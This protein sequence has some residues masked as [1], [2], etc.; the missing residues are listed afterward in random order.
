MAGS[1]VFFMKPPPDVNSAS[2]P[3]ADVA[4]RS[5]RGVGKI[6]EGELTAI[7][8][9]PCFTSRGLTSDHGEGGLNLYSF[10]LGTGVAVLLP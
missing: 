8:A 6:R 1:V 9:V 10:C 5:S 7:A 2:G 3:P 4:P